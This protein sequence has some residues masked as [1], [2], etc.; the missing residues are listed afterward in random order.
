MKRLF[1]RLPSNWSFGKL[2]S[3]PMHA[4]LEKRR[5]VMSYRTLISTLVFA[6]FG[7]CF[8][9]EARAQGCDNPDFCFDFGIPVTV[10][11]ITGSSITCDLQ[12]G[13]AS[14]PFNKLDVGPGFPLTGTSGTFTQTGTATCKKLPTGSESPPETCA[15]EL[16]WTGVTISQCMEDN[17]TFTAKGSCGDGSLGVT[18]TITCASGVVNL[19]IAGIMGYGNDTC[20]K[21]FPALPNGLLAGQVLD[22]TVTT[23]GVPQKCEGPFVA[24][25]NLKERY[26]NSGDPSS[27][28]GAV[29]CTP[30]EG[31]TRTTNKDTT[32]LTSAVAFD[33][34]VRQTVNRKC[35]GNKQG[36]VNI[37]ILGSAFF[38]VDDVDPL[39]LACGGSFAED[40]APLSHCM[41]QD[42]NHDGFPDLACKVDACPIFAPGLAASDG[43]ATAVCT[44]KLNS[45]TGIHGTDDNVK[46]NH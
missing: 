20:A 1:Y 19:G 23:K 2:F 14:Q 11:N 13:G 4:R 28:P 46:V 21:V 22:L 38:A 40:L 41:I 45:G 30:I 34:D 6:A 39:S 29:D 32:D 5:G 43:I 25:S 8:S 36:N 9:G 12:P 15:F 26:C 17:K 10:D 42:T 35:Q 24:I 31:P 7:F 27:Y 33:F 16:T 3:N 37:D 18:G 44:G